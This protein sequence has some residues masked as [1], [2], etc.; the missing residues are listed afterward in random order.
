VGR[1]SLKCL[2]GFGNSLVNFLGGRGPW[3]LSGKF[4]KGV[5]GYWQPSEKFLEG[6]WQPFTRGLP[7]PSDHSPEGVQYPT[8]EILEVVNTP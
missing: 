7:K 6:Y 1:P 4:V 8:E 5:W 2:G 3:Q